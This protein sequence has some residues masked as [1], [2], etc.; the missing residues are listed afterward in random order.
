MYVGMGAMMIHRSGFER[1]ISELPGLAYSVGDNTP[2]LLG[3]IHIG[4]PM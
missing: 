4:L 3:Q 2:E 1:M